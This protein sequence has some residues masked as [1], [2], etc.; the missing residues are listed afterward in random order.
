V[1][2]SANAEP[3]QRQ[4]TEGMDDKAPGNP[5]A[6]GI[7]RYRCAI[8]DSRNPMSLRTLLL[9]ALAALLTALPGVALLSLRDI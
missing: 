1:P 7:P 8:F 6:A 4:C 3:G 5:K 2:R 9:A